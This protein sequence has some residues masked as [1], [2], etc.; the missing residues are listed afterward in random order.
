MQKVAIVTKADAKESNTKYAQGGI[1]VVT[2]TLK[3]SFDQHIQDTLTA[4]SGLCD[5]KNC[6]NGRQGRAR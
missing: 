4:G 3:D 6:G 1:A 5:P 2:D